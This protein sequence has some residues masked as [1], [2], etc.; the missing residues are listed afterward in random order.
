MEGEW[1]GKQTFMTQGAPMTAT[2]TA[3]VHFAIGGRYLEEAL[4]STVE[5]RKPT[6]TR[7]FTTYDPD[8]KTYRA[9]WFNDSSRGALEM[10][11]AFEGNKLIL[12][13]KPTKMGD[14]STVLRATYEKI[15]DS[16]FGYRLELKRPD[17]WLQLF[18]TVYQ[19]KG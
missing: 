15:S 14:S 17:S 10:E 12:T 13:S 6:D 8:S 4:I 9:W 1:N 5:G 18:E 2:V 16:Q 19:R 11:G 3:T 7:H